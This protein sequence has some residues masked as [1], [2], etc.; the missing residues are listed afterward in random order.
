MKRIVAILALVSIAACGPPTARQIDEA[1]QSARLA[2]WRGDLA[3]ALAVADAGIAL[4][5]SQPASATAWRLRLLRA[6]ILLAKPDVQQALP[7]LSEPIPDGAEFAPL[8]GR[9]EYLVARSQVLQGRLAEALTT[10]DEAAREAPDDRELRLDAEVLGGQVRMRL[11]KWDEA[12]SRLNDTVEEAVKDGDR[13]REVLALNNL[14]MGMLVRNRCDEALQWFE[15][16]LSFKDLDQMLV[17]SGAM[18]NAGICYARLGRFDRAV[19]VQQQA[20]E[21]HQRR[22]VATYQEQ[23]LGELGTTYLLQS[24]VEHARPYL[25]Q[26]FKIATDIGN[27]EDAALWA[28]NLASAALVAGQLDDAERFNEEAKRLNPPNRTNRVAWT[29]LYSGRIAA[30][31]GKTDEA[32]R[33]FEQV[34]TSSEG[35]PRLKWAAHEGLADLASDSGDKAAARRHFE[36]ALQAIERTRA[37]L[38]KTDYKLSFLSELIRFYRNY[39]DMLVD[40]GA[41]ENALEV[42]DSSRGRVLA[43]GHG[44]APPARAQ[45]STFIRLAARS[46]TVLVSYWLGRV[47]SFVWAVDGRGV[48]VHRLPPAAEIEKLV[49]QHV[50]SIQNSMSDPLAARGGPGDQLFQLLVAPVMGSMA[51]GSSVIIVPDGALHGLNFE[52]LPVDGPRRHYWIE[53]VQVQVAPALSLLTEADAAPAAAPSLLVIGDPTSTDPQFPPLRYASTEM[54]SI[55]GHFAQ[56]HTTSYRGERASPAA[57]R[58][59]AP[60]RF[61]LVHFAAHA[62]ANVDSPL[63]SAVILAGPDRAYKLYARDVAT[64]PLRAELVTVSACRSA[65]ERAYTGEGLIG[66]AWAFLRAGARRVVA[67]LWDVD[68]RSTAE[69]MDWMYARLAAGDSP[70]SA[71]RQA[72]LGLLA[73]GGPTAKPYY[74]APFQVFT[75]TVGRR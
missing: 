65:G 63:D 13:Y 1:F 32:R 46:G 33:L 55:A 45:A 71:L 16:V 17:Y 40:Q 52:T 47:H 29:T 26:A 58:E 62:A 66:F 30:A 48:K 53:D 11:G 5:G 61:S 22:G 67:G 51:S 38:L 72:K 3:N 74:W 34:L 27:N 44:I 23:A 20:V 18:N 73:R 2:M 15:R 28:G 35:Q 50:A 70:P 56:D 57:Y 37:D 75:V 36:A 31:R 14:G 19:A 41:I 64:M 43:D 54:S 49:A 68:D 69:L 12:E 42:A 9:Q 59:A 39:V 21:S 7:T 4:A 60:D 8:R 24:D 25:Q 6:E 10:L